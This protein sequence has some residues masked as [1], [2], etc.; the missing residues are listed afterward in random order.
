MRETKMGKVERIELAPAVETGGDVVENGRMKRGFSARTLG[1]SGKWASGYRVVEA[2]SSEE[3]KEL[4]QRK[5][6]DIVYMAL[7]KIRSDVKV[8]MTTCYR[9]GLEDLIDQALN[10]SAYACI[11][12]PFEVGRVAKLLE[13]ILAG[14]T[15]A[16]VRKMEDEYDRKS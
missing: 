13:R 7:R 16:E 3:A 2:R 10:E 1:L 15:K 12:K 4:V 9:E 5:S 11:Y 14:K 8:V 6:F